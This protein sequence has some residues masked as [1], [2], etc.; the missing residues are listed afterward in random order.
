MT[1]APS[2]NDGRE[3]VSTDHS[4]AVALGRRPPE[5][6]LDDVRRRLLN[7]IVVVVAVVAIPNVAG[8]VSRT[9]Q[10][11][12]QPVMA[13]QVG[14]VAVFLVLAAFRR[15]LPYR[16]LAAAVFV[17]IPANAFAA[18]MAFGLIGQGVLMIVVWATVVAIF[19]G[20]RWGMAAT[21][22]GVVGMAAIGF[23]VVSERIVWTVDMNGYA[24]ASSSWISAVIGCAFWA[25]LTA[26]CVGRSHA[27]LAGALRTSEERSVELE[28]MNRRLRKLASQLVDAEDA[29][30]RRLASVLHDGVGQKLYAA[31][32]RLGTLSLAEHAERVTSDVDETMKL[33]DEAITLGRVLTQELFPHILFEAGLDGALEWLAD[34][35]RRLHG[36]EVGFEDRTT[37]L[38]VADDVALS[39]FQ[40]VRE[41][42]HN[43]AKHA[44]ASKVRVVLDAQGDNLEVTVT[45]DGIGF[46]SD[47]PGAEDQQ[48]EGFGLF[49]I[50]ERLELV[51][52]RLDIQSRTG[53]GTTAMVT[54]PRLPEP[55][56]RP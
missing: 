4:S 9:T 18:L 41:L 17:L 30:R 2:Q 7:A 47:G 16:V 21:L 8:S 38:D 33:I 39:I 36:V 26:G 45:D 54:V 12:F 14:S 27:E 44:Q 15:R 6:L 42:L 46:S 10:I 53:H 35:H 19:S 31:K 32:L 28:R 55:E 56:G 11:G 20:L 1:T 34:E 48:R 29:E 52:G 23:G 37:G 13:F 5:Q 22:V 51:G 49:S 25:L 40:A 3:D 24:V 50:T 43:T